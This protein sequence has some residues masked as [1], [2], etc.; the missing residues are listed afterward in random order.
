MRQEAAMALT[1][2]M[3]ESDGLRRRRDNACELTGCPGYYETPGCDVAG[4]RY[5][6]RGYMRLTWCDNYRSYSMWWFGD[7]RLRSNPDLVAS[8]D[9]LAWNYG[10]W[11]W[12]V[13]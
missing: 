7:D 8:D 6:G 11:L 3:D 2:F 1:Q 4:Q 13:S 12:Q 5:F 9:N 10:F